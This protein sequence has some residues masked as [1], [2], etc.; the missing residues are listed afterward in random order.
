MRN[1]F[2]VFETNKDDVQRR[3]N[4]LEGAITSIL[5]GSLDEQLRAG[6]EHTAHELVGSLETL[7]LRRGCELARDLEQSLALPRGSVAAEG[8]H[9]AGCVRALRC[10]LDDQLAQ[11]CSD[12][13]AGDSV[14]AGV[15]YHD[16]DLLADDRELRH[17]SPET[18]L[19]A[20]KSN[21][22]TSGLILVVDDDIATR[23]LLV[24]I[25]A[26]AGYDVRDVGSAGEARRALEH[27]S[28][29]LLLSDVSMPGETG[30]DLIRFALCEHPQTATLMISA[31]EDPRI[32]QVAMDFGAYG[33][34]SKP[35]RRSAV[36]IGVMNAL[37]RRDMEAQERVARETLECTLRFRTGALAQALKR[38]EG[39][40]QQGRLLQ[41]ETIYRW[42]QAAEY[43]DPG[44]AR[45]VKRMSRYCAVLGHTFG[46]PV[47][48]LEPASVLH[49]VGKIA[50]ADSIL[51]KPAPL[52]ADE[53]FAIETHADI[54]YGL[55]R[56]SCSSL[57]D[58]AALVARTHHEK[59]DGS[60]YPRGL[61]GTNIP[62]EGRI[63]AVADVFD[64]M[65]SHRVYS[66][67]WSVDAT[68]AWM[69]RERGKHFDPTVLDALLSSMDEILAIRS[70]LGSE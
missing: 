3:V 20:V 32:A 53:R 5:A 9:L 57:L 64:A 15:I 45:H 56:G 31:L 39:A 18:G 7:G 35:V 70:A 65:T 11:G 40:T 48:S 63:A 67:A 58:L 27:E 42:A 46:L 60:G 44:I 49:D 62:L 30:L 41:A 1:R 16:A 33:Y 25:L 69:R 37:R 21:P 13:G 24:W 68:I 19:T 14:G 17:A 6:A 47:E 23:R 50:I 26:D 12:E 10:E 52:T 22:A 51:L 2:S 4:R 66:P 43:R 29:A 59:F 34:L 55:L 36:L 8:T 38:L 61:S 54:G 28:V